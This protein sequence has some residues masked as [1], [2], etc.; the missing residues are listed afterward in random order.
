LEQGPA[1]LKASED[2][3]D[4]EQTSD[5]KRRRNSAASARHRLKKKLK[6]QKLEHAARTLTERADYLQRRV[7]MLEA[8]VAYL[9][10]LIVIRHDR[11]REEAL[12]AAADRLRDAAAAMEAPAQP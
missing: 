4:D 10:E 5:E 12:A 8:E 2:S 11:D 6:E 9:R 7:Q 1:S 3:D